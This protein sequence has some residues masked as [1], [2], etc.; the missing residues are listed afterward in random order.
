MQSLA[1]CY[2]DYRSLDEDKFRMD[3]EEGLQTAHFVFD[4][5]LGYFSEAQ[6]MTPQQAKIA[7]FSTFHLLCR[8]CFPLLTHATVHFSFCTTLLP[9]LYRLRICLEGPPA[10]G[11]TRLLFKVAETIPKHLILRQDYQT[12]A[13]LRRGEN[14]DCRLI[15]RDEEKASSH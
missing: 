2:H 8:Q 14:F 3:P 5:I 1:L 13:V 11:K 9:E 15:L 6:S 4:E 7:V 12:S 10:S